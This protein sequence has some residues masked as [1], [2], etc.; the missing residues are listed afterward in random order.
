MAR[1]IAFALY[2]GANTPLAGAS[3]SFLVYKGGDG[4][5]RTPP[6]I[7]DRGG[8]VYTFTIPTDD[9]TAGVAFLVT[10]GAVPASFAGTD[11][12]RVQA[13]ALYDNVTLALTPGKAPAFATYVNA[14]GVAKTSPV[15]SDFGAGLYAFAPTVADYKTGVA[16]EIN[17]GSGVLPAR[18]NGWAQLIEGAPESLA[19]VAIPS[20]PVIA[21]TVTETAYAR[22]LAQLLP[23][24]KL[25]NLEPDSVT[26]KTLLALAAEFARVDGRAA[27]LVNETDPRTALETLDDWERVL[28]LPD[29]CLTSIPSSVNERRSAI[30]SKYTARGGQS[31][32]YYEQL[33]AQLGYTATVSEYKVCRSGSARSGDRCNGTAWAFAWLV[34]ISGYEIG[35]VSRA[36]SGTARSGDRIQGFAQLDVEC[37][38]REAAPAHTFPLFTYTL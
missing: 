22:Q 33:A 30:T 38:I 3:P 19:P 4:V 5:S 9:V 16:F 24:G 25:W 23:P 2:D 12:G 31:R 27:D 10:T 20:E 26:S 14:S 34:T 8:G 18:L 1:L 13:F 6:T 35:T 7:Y 36:R 17:P 32:A 28:G 11:G 21:P 15:I 29:S 37:I